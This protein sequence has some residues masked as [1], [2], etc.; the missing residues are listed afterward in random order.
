MSDL[1]LE[2]KLEIAG[3]SPSRYVYCNLQGLEYN[4]IFL[5]SDMNTG[6]WSDERSEQD[7]HSNK[8]LRRF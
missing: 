3:S 2:R 5:L 8:V 7:L 6:E 4:I 1:H